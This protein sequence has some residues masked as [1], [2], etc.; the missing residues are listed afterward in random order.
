MQVL[1]YRRLVDPP[2]GK[3]MDGVIEKSLP[4]RPTQSD[5]A[6]DRRR[7]RNHGKLVF[8][9]PSDKPPQTRYDY[10]AT[11]LK[12]PVTSMYPKFVVFEAK[13]IAKTFDPADTEGIQK[14]AKNRLG[15]TCDGTQLGTRW[16]TRRIPQALNRHDPGAKNRAYR[17]TKGREILDVRYARWIFICLP[18]ALGTAS[19]KLYVF[20]DVVAAGMDLESRAPKPRKTDTADDNKL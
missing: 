17:E 19:L 4:G 1:Q 5:V 10:V 2:K 15:N 12:K 18:G 14:E 9:P 13:H 6:L 20:I 8:M 3:G 16:T 11:E 7:D